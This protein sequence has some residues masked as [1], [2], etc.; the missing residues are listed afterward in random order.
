MEGYSQRGPARMSIRSH[1]PGRLAVAL[2]LACLTVAPPTRAAASVT[3][4]QLSSFPPSP[5][6]GTS[7]VDFLE[8]SVTGNL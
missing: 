3:S 8:P 7:N 6:C 5:A 2:A 1:A 4:G